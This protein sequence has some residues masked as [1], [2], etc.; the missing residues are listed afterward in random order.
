MKKFI[1]TIISA[2]C[3]ILISSC[4]KEYVSY[5]TPENT[6][7]EKELVNYGLLEKLTGKWETNRIDVKRKESAYFS[8]YGLIEKTTE[9]TLTD[10]KY[11]VEIQ[12]NK[13]VIHEIELT[14]SPD[15]MTGEITIDYDEKSGKLNISILT[16]ED[17]DNEFYNLATMS[18]VKNK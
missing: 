12:D 14:D 8:G 15:N 1:V 17:D 6:K 13:I 5:G 9:E 7:P 3:L 18:F 11:K 4:E 2:L 10:V 16:Y